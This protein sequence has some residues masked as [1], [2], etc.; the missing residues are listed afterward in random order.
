MLTHLF[1]GGASPATERTAPEM[2][3]PRNV[4]SAPK[5]GW[6]TF[7]DETPTGLKVKGYEKGNLEKGFTIRLEPEPEE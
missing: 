5:D 1:P 4:T 6:K 7:T 3:G 2:I